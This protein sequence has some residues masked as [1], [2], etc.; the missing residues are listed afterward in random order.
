MLTNKL[1]LF[2]IVIALVNYSSAVETVDVSPEEDCE[3]GCGSYVVAYH[4]HDFDQD[5]IV[6]YLTAVVKEA[7]PLLIVGVLLFVI[8]IIWGCCSCCHCGCC[9]DPWDMSETKRKAFGVFVILLSCS[10][11]VIIFVGFSVEKQQTSSIEGVQHRVTD[12]A[13]FINESVQL[14]YNGTD[15]VYEL[16]P[17]AEE[18]TDTIINFTNSYPA[19]EDEL[20]FITELVDVIENEFKTLNESVIEAKDEIGNTNQETS[21]TADD[22]N[23]QIEMV[24]GYRSRIVRAFLSIIL[25]II[26]VQGLVS[27]FDTYCPDGRRPNQIFCCKFLTV[28]IT[29]IFIIVML[30]MFIIGTV[31]L[32]LTMLMSDICV[33]PDTIILNNVNDSML[34]YFIKCDMYTETQKRD[35]NPLTEQF[36]SIEVGLAESQGTIDE[37]RDAVLTVGNITIPALVPPAERAAMEAALEALMGELN[38]STNEMQEIHNR[39]TIFYK[40]C[41]NHST[42][43]D[44]QQC[45][46]D[47]YEKLPIDDISVVSQLSCDTLNGLY[48]GFIVQLCD[49]VHTGIARI[50]Q[51]VVSL[52]V[53]MAILEWAKRIIRP[54]A[55]GYDDDDFDNKGSD[56][57]MSYNEKNKPRMETRYSNPQLESDRIEKG[58][59]LEK[60]DVDE[61]YDEK[62]SEHSVDP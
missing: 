8:F 41:G 1:F 42:I 26:L 22:F 24:N 17:I 61:R 60:G 57:Y 48:N 5:D 16:F 50:M 4:K 28:F 53:V 33:T 36:G 3:S 30:I 20:D 25:I 52:A 10:V 13:D 55:V 6:G 43:I 11:A 31:L 54:S 58:E 9:G 12:V 38:T 18:T 2:A 49:D 32:I 62:D 44:R 21:D 23:E 27:I 39:V 37:L 46:E 35:G 34:E 29:W 14:L 51:I 47:G 45:D 7:A 40:G 59:D 19:L 56:G 15:I